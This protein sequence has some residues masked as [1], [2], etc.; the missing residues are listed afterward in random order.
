MGDNYRIPLVWSEDSPLDQFLTV[1][2]YPLHLAR[3]RRHKV[4]WSGTCDIPGVR[5]SREYASAEKQRAEIERG[6]RTFFD[7]VGTVFVAM[8]TIEAERCHKILDGL[9][10]ARLGGGDLT[11]QLSDR[12]LLLAERCSSAERAAV[13]G[14]NSSDN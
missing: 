3:I 10:V 12:I 11:L 13:P 6:I 5:T 2:E 9:G 1:G 4:Q 7:L 8:P 14:D